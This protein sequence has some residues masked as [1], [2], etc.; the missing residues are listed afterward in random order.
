MQKRGISPDGRLKFGSSLETNRQ[1]LYPESNPMCNRSESRTTQSP[2]WRCHWFLPAVLLLAGLR[3]QA[4]ENDNMIMY[5]SVGGENRIA[6]YAFDSASGDLSPSSE[7]AAGGAP[8]ALCVD[9]KQQFLYAAIRTSDSVAT[10]AIDPQSGKLTERGR[11]SVVSNPV[12]LATDKQGKYLLTSYYAAHKAAVYPIGGDGV[13]QSTATVVLDTDKNPHS[14]NVD[15][16]NRFVFVPN[17]G[18]DKVLQFRFDATSG[19]LTPNT[20]PEVFLGERTGPRHFFFH[21]SKPW[22]YF[23]NEIGSSVT[24]TRLDP[25]KGTLEPFQ[26]IST[27][28]SDFSGNNTCAH[29]E[30]TPDGK[31]LYA[32]NRGHDSLACYSIEASSGRLTSLG[33]VATE[34]TPRAFNLDPSGRF[35][36]AAGQ[37]SGRL[38]SYRVAA[39]GKLQPLKT[40]EVGKGP[41]WVL[42]LKR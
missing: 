35:L 34:K 3:T 27:L 39:D 19:K 2:I 4:A 24:A 28:P 17:T 9:P 8:G 36:V 26:T 6:I 30:I 5:V 14:I 10:L 33:N 41:A 7:F 25:E 15:R 20:P 32:S 21:P 13:V 12:Y 1:I 23:V 31:Y 16:Q 37:G 38:A 22:V 18:A 11:T 40:Y 29:I 42:I